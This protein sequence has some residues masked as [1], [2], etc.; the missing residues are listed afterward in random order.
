[1]SHRVLVLQTAES[2]QVDAGESVLEAATRQGVALAHECT[3]GGC[4]TCRVRLVEGSV[5]YDEFPIALTPE[6]AEQG[7]ALVCQARAQSD[8]VISTEAVAPP[9]CEP[10]LWGTDRFD[11]SPGLKKN[12]ARLIWRGLA[13]RSGDLGA[14][15]AFGTEWADWAVWPA[16]AG[17]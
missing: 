15:G 4:G 6:E 10:Q 7:Y 17:A 3:F 9:V 11:T 8:L 2:F 13:G 5:H 12:G 14:V 16:V 1:M